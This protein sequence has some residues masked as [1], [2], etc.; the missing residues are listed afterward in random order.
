MI[1]HDLGVVEHMSDRVA[2]MYLGRIVET[3]GWREIFERPAPSLY[4]RADRGDS[5]RGVEK[6]SAVVARGEL[7]NPLSPRRD[8]RFIHAAPSLPIHAGANP[9]PRW[10]RKPQGISSDACAPTKSRRQGGA[11]VSGMD[12]N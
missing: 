12:M 4:A 10:W 1:S 3:G 5:R 7:P 2:V 9:R 6:P 8:A 11:N